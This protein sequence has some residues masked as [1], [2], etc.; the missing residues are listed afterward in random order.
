MTQILQMFSIIL[1]FNVI[2]VAAKKK[3]PERLF[4]GVMALGE[5]VRGLYN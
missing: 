3:C 1:E 4:T 2:Y 5:H